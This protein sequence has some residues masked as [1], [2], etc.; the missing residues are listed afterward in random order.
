MDFLV[1][2]TYSMHLINRF[3]LPGMVK[4]HSVDAWIIVL[5]WICLVGVTV[6]SA[7]IQ[8]TSVDFDLLL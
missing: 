3:H 4:S 2:S 8:M 7:V 5:L 6:L 1:Y